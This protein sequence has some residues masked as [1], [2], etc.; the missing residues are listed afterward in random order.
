MAAGESQ[1]VRLWVQSLWS[2]LSAGETWIN[3]K[4]TRSQI[5]GEPEGTGVKAR[6]GAAGDGPAV[7]TSHL[8]P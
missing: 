5:P 1:V 7:S 3:T 8:T 2:W 4:D 6:A